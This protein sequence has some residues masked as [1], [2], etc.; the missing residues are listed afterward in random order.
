MGI[1][2]GIGS[3]AIH[4]ESV[5]HAAR[6][7]TLKAQA[8][9][10]R[11]AVSSAAGTNRRRSAGS[12]TSK[13]SLARASYVTTFGVT[14]PKGMKPATMH[15]AVALQTGMSAPTARSVKPA[16][17]RA[18]RT[19]PSVLSQ[20]MKGAQRGL[21]ATSPGKIAVAT[22]VI[23]SV[24]AYRRSDTAVE[25]IAAA[26]ST[27][28]SSGFVLGAA[29]AAKWMGAPAKYVSPV[30]LGVVAAYGAYDGA[31]EDK[32]MVRGAA[33]GTIRSFD[34][35]SLFMKQGLAER[36]FNKVFGGADP[37]KS[38]G[39]RFPPWADKPFFAKEPEQ[40]MIPKAIQG[41]KDS[42][43]PKPAAP[44][45]SPA[46]WSTPMRYQPQALP[47]EQHATTYERTYTKGP[48]AGTT[49]VVRLRA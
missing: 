40:G 4:H 15:Q 39:F 24:N 6:A 20:A 31:K 21:A 27:A 23:Q 2:K 43:K 34:P 28:A 49:E 22:T 12:A 41:L 33:R 35:S 29:G 10:D 5:K 14:P 17:S 47:S 11:R 45:E 30:A 37:G 48:K 44:T 9:I 1:F 19:A 16:V 46:P 18:P 32:N 13:S 26:A 7:G 38:A 42:M 36:G 8:A 3:F 25:G